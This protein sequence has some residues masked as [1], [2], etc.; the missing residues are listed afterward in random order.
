LRQN[1]EL[2][3]FLERVTVVHAAVQDQ[4]GEAEFLIGPS[5]AMGKVKGSAGRDTVE[6][7]EN[8][9]VEA[10]SIDGFIENSGNQFPDIVKMDIEGGEV[11]ALPGMANLLQTRHPL[12]L[13][14]LHGLESAE[15]SW[16]QLRNSGYRICRM[17]RD[18]PQV[19]NFEEL[20]WKSYLVAFP[21]EQ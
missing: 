19:E 20:N 4:A 3:G 16:W 7:L 8:I 2:N 1:V 15:A 13:I 14:E 10:I 11:L 9:N 21:D 6:Y 18:F 5:S 12:V 17:E